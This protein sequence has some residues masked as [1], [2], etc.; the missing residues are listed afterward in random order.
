MIQ[1]LD[2]MPDNMIGFRAQGEVVKDDFTHT[3]IPCVEQQIEKTGK[4]N[5]LLLLDTSI[6][7]FSAGA[8]WQ[9]AMM[10]IKNITKWNRAAIV[11][12]S[13]G[14]RRFTDFFSIL[15]PGEFKGFHKEDLDKAIL[16]TS[17]QTEE[18]G[19]DY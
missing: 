1:Q 6:K 19:I 18:P 13:E 8:W 12:D 9:D 5:Y 4:L 11:S 10:G 3:V 7:D 2:N 14:V 17:E 15:M 16:W